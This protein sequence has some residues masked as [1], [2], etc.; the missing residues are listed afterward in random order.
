M[1]SKV[2]RVA[3]FGISCLT[4]P[5]RPSVR[6]NCQAYMESNN[7]KSA[8]GLVVKALPCKV[9]GSENVQKLR[10]EIA[11]RVPGLK[12]IDKPVVWLFPDIFVCMDC[13]IAEFAVPEDQL[14]MLAKREAATGDDRTRLRV[15]PQ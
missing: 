13:G 1:L 11:M 12:N 14:R 3:Y 6:E 4:A 9:C 2:A 15:N 7:S 5:I 10:G 8:E